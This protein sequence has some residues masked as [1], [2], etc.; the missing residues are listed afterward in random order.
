MSERIDLSALDTRKGAQEGVELT[1]KH[2]STGAPLA[3]WTL[4]VRG[5]DSE[6][7]QRTSDEQ[8]R[9]RLDRIA[10]GK[11]PTVEELN[12]EAT[13]LSATLIAGWPD[14]FDLDG[15]PFA[16]SES[17]A[18]ALIVRFPWIREQVE[19]AAADRGNF[20]PGPASS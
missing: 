2:P 12:A 10:M 20:L 17:A 13:E 1:L 15:K 18:Q 4:R 14:K 16:Y 9:R 19:K 11:R 6:A 7:Y 3:G 5:Y 8:Q